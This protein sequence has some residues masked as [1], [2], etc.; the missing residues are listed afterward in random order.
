MLG[1]PIVVALVHRMMVDV[2]AVYGDA[3]LVDGASRLRA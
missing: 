1:A 2:W 3:L